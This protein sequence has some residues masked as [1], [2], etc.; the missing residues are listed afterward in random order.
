[1]IIKV[2]N[3]DMNKKMVGGDPQNPFQ[4]PLFLTIEK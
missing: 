1:M 4:P 3:C 2:K